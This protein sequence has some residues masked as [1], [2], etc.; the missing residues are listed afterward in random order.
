[1][2]PA[3]VITLIVSLATN[4]GQL[5]DRVRRSKAETRAA[6]QQTDAAAGDAAAKQETGT[7]AHYEVLI[8]RLERRIDAGEKRQEVADARIA[9]LSDRERECL[10]DRGIQGE[11]IK[12]LE[13]ANGEVRAMLDASER[14]V[15]ELESL[16]ASQATPA[17]PA[18]GGGP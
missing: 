5:V 14:R 18:P 17:R 9:D 15:D 4:A 3:L 8:R 16:L 13:A 12:N 6:D 7:I 11:K 2:D 1:M 10:I